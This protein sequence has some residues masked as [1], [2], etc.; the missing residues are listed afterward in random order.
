LKENGDIEIAKDS[1]VLEWLM[2]TAYSFKSDFE[3]MNSFTFDTAYKQLFKF[4][5]FRWQKSKELT[6]F[7][8]ILKGVNLKVGDFEKISY[9][10]LIM[11]FVNENKQ[12]IHRLKVLND[13]VSSLIGVT[14]Y[15]G[16]SLDK[17]GLVDDELVITPS[18]F[19]KDNPIDFIKQSKSEID[20]YVEEPISDINT[21]IINHEK[22]RTIIRV[23]DKDI[24]EAVLKQNEFGVYIK[25]TPS[26]YEHEIYVNFKDGR[27]EALNG[28]SDIADAQL[29]LGA[30]DQRLQQSIKKKLDKVKRYGLFSEMKKTAMKRMETVL[31]NEENK[32]EIL[33]KYM[34]GLNKL[35]DYLISRYVGD[36]KVSDISRTIINRLGTV[37]EKLLSKIC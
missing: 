30:F 19:I 36:I 1:D 16:F 8:D 23:Q 31:R 35:S 15:M 26:N 9:E 33:E 37:F 11:N 29:F 12:M 27:L 7:D 21:R 5:T 14:T 17:S 10:N 18:I 2:K 4:A 22:N 6:K 25:L 20:Y 32:K 28:L 13:V 3:Y 24:S 34:N